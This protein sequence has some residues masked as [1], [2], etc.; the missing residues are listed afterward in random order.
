M[1]NPSGAEI[2]CYVNPRD[3]HMALIDRGLG[4]WA[5]MALFPL[6]FAAIGLGGLYAAFLRKPKKEPTSRTKEAEI[7]STP[8]RSRGMAG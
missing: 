7:H 3:P 5:L 2:T 6:P 4:W 8:T 1:T